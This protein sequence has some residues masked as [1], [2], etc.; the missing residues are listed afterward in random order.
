MDNPFKELYNSTLK[1]C[2]IKPKDPIIDHELEMINEERTE[3]GLQG[4]EIVGGFIDLNIP[5]PTKNVAHKEY[6]KIDPVAIYRNKMSLKNVPYDVD[7]VNVLYNRTHP[8][9]QSFTSWIKNAEK[10][11]AIEGKYYKNFVRWMDSN[12]RRSLWKEKCATG[13]QRVSIPE[14]NGIKLDNVY[15][16]YD[17]DYNIV[18]NYAV[19][20][21]GKYTV[22]VNARRQTGDDIPVDITKKISNYNRQLVNESYFHQY[23]EA[24]FYGS[25][26]IE[27]VFLHPNEYEVVDR[28][29]VSYAN[30][31]PNTI[32]KLFQENDPRLP[33]LREGSKAAY[34]S[35]VNSFQGQQDIPEEKKIEANKEE[36]TE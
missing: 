11:S 12:L 19:Y 23:P 4:E 14:L 21:N 36:T 35:Y 5:V 34:E 28:E 16:L 9:S 17:F 2:P 6:E 31:Q 24:E 18:W 22:I 33:Q 8:G 32:R 7:K 27:D 10:K 1:I 25:K 13:I 30:C 20:A 3:N 15:K 26:D 29:N